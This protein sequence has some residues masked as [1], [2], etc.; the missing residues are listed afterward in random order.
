MDPDAWLRLPPPDEELNFIHNM[1]KLFSPAT[2]E[3]IEK[4]VTFYGANLIQALVLVTTL[5]SSMEKRTQSYHKQMGTIG[6]S[7]TLLLI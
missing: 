5:P 7:F 6:F 1:R 2:R 3:S 4:S